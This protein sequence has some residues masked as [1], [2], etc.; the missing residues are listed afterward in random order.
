MINYLPQ[1]PYIFTGSVLENLTLGA[2][3]EITQKEI[4]QAVELAEI[5][6]DIEQMEL[7]YQSQLSSEATS[8]SGGQKQRIALARAL[9]SPAKVLIL[10]EATSNLD[11]ITEKKILDNLFKMNKTII[12]IA[13]RLSVAEKSKHI[14]VVDQGHIIEEGSHQELLAAGG[15]YAGLYYV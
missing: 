5:R 4:A 8:L 10:D 6:H 15:F 3:P 12:F 11:L 1:E 2:S 7:G 9:L 14:V 13:H